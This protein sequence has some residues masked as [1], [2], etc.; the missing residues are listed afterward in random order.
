MLLPDPASYRFCPIC[1]APLAPKIGKEGE[2]PRPWC[3]A[4]GFVAYSNPRVAACT[5][6]VV[7]GGIVLLQRANEPQRG[8][9]VFPGVSWTAGKRC[10][11]RPFA[12]RGRK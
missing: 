10:R 7:D 5:I 4:C 8:K 3:D 11:P 6:A 9:W 2:V 1:A 12:R